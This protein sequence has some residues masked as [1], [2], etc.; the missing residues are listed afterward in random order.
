MR[1]STYTLAVQLTP[2]IA[3]A[4][5]DNPDGDHGRQ[6]PDA[7]GVRDIPQGWA[8]AYLLASL[9]RPPVREVPGVRVVKPPRFDLTA[10][11]AGPV[12]IGALLDAQPFCRVANGRY[13]CPA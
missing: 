1:Q 13:R 10:E 11:T 8:S 6:S 9:M 2:A 3:T 12:Q 7:A 4:S 5:W